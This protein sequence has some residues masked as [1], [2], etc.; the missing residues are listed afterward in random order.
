[1]A[2]VADQLWGVQLPGVMKAVTAVTSAV[3]TAADGAMTHSGVF[4]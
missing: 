3:T 4:I 2:G 1:M